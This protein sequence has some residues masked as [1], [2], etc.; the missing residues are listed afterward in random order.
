MLFV[1]ADVI[2]SSIWFKY[3]MPKI[4]SKLKYWEKRRVQFLLELPAVLAIILLEG[5]IENIILLMSYF[6]YMT[7][8]FV[9][10]MLTTMMIEFHKKF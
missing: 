8:V 5:T 9:I 10:I 6:V 4:D 3:Q 1:L 2:L 7:I